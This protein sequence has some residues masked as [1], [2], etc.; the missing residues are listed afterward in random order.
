MPNSQGGGEAAFRGLDYQKKIIAYLSLGMLSKE[1]PIRNSVACEHLDDI[2]VEEDSKL[3]YYQVK[4][5]TES[6]LPKSKIIDSIKLFSS[7]ESNKNEEKFNEYILISNAKIRKFNNNL[8][9]HSFDSLDNVIKDEI[10]SLEEV[11]TKNELLKRVYFMKGPP[12]EEIS[13]LIV[14]SLVHTFKGDENYSYDYINIQKE[15]LSHINRMCPGP[16]DL[17]D[18]KII[19]E[20][21]KEQYHLKHKTIT[22]DIINMIIETNRKSS[23]KPTRRVTQSLT[24]KYNIMP[25]HLSGEE[26]KTIHDLINEYNS[27]S[28]DDELRHTYILK[29]NELSSRLNLY[30]DQIFLDFLKEQFRSC[31][32]KHIILEC[33]FI[34][35]NLIIVVKQRMKALF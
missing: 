9:K 6:S 18:K 17:E 1:P 25:S 19:Y 15:L 12:L 13:S 2:E 26:A 8:V 10:K 22:P 5:T 3:I 4:S 24:I 28:E 31:K 16:I 21:E 20:S 23:T 27:F 33:S 34:L 32:N 30:R 11:K 29:F 14:T 7:I 35:H